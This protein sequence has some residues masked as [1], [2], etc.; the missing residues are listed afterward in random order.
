MG[1]T[2][3]RRRTSSSGIPNPNDSYVL[4][5]MAFG[6]M[7]ERGGSHFI[8]SVDGAPIGE[9]VGEAHHRADT[10][11]AVV[12]DDRGLVGVTTSKVQGRG[13]NAQNC[14]ACGVPLDPAPGS[15]RQLYCGS[16]CR[17]T[18][19]RAR[20]RSGR[21]QVPRVTI[22]PLSTAPLEVVGR[23]FRWPGT[24]PH[25]PAVIRAIVDQEVGG[26]P[27]TGAFDLLG[28]AKCRK[29]ASQ[30][31]QFGSGCRHRVERVLPR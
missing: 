10:P 21:C 19:Y 6:H 9:P 1:H 7:L 30:H 24:M 23:G 15:R 17:Q 12:R 31:P 27:M 26:G 3:K 18:A 22:N 28:G 2:L 25:D 5:G 20:K 29:T 11:P 4:G 16:A 8:F 13:G 14:A